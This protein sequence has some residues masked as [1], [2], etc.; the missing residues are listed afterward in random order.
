MRT[1]SVFFSLNLHRLKK[2]CPSR[3]TNK[4]WKNNTLIISCLETNEKHIPHFHKPQ[5]SHQDKHGGDIF[6]DGR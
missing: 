1:S 6:N 5:M 2:Y 3:K 4:G